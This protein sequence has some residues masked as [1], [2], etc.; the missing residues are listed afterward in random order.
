MQVWKYP[1]NRRPR[2]VQYIKRPS[3]IT[4]KRKV[5][6][7]RAV[8]SNKMSTDVIHIW[9]I[10]V[11]HG[12]KCMG[13]CTLNVFH[14]LLG[15][16]KCSLNKV[17]SNKIITDVIHIIW[18]VLVLH[19]LRWKGKCT[20]NVFHE[21]LGKGKCTLNKVQTKWLRMLYM[22]RFSPSRIKVKGKVYITRAVFHE[23]PGR[24]SYMNCFS[25]SWI[26]MKGKCILDV[27]LS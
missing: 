15:K 22:N 11:L 16:G 2:V 5:Y 13:K 7:K 24:D 19:G 17:Y 1:T 26:K 23:L 14:E 18:N 6:I 25:P 21:L 3:R 12:L 4:V 20:L 27:N 8:C 10:L 9:T